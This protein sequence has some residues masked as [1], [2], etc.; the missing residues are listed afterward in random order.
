M[1]NFLSDNGIFMSNFTNSQKQTFLV[2]YA[3]LHKMQL[4]ELSDNLC[5]DFRT[6]HKNNC[7]NFSNNLENLVLY[8]FNVL[9]FSE[10]K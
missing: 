1:D 3:E 10:L 6:M 5:S 7:L 2:F 8:R 4:L 9:N